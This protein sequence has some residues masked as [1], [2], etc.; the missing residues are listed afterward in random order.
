M[1]DRLANR[2]NPT[3]LYVLELLDRINGRRP[4]GM[5]D[6]KIERPKLKQYVGQL[7]SGKSTRE[8]ELAKAALI[9]WIDEMLVNAPW[10]HQKAWERNTLEFEY[11]NTLDRA[12]LFYDQAKTAKSLSPPDALETFYLCVALGFL[13]VYRSADILR[14][15][16]QRSSAPARPQAAPAPPPP[17]PTE[18]PPPRNF[19]DSWPMTNPGTD[20]SWDKLPQP[21]G[22]PPAPARDDMIDE[23]VFDRPSGGPQQGV[24]DLPNTL[25]GWAAPVYA[26]I[27]PGRQRPFQPKTPSDSQRD[28]R[29]LSGWA[30][31]QR[32]MIAFLWAIMLTVIAGGLA[33][34]THLSPGG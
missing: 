6:P 15:N 20:D 31:C 7:D 27:V 32:A 24:M 29:P 30:S 14:R 25:D 18:A 17:R 13:G 10:P 5:P 1:N 11:F 33:A 19:G 2:V 9:Y 8:D 4:G 16:Q 3:I 12:W 28:A 26:Q 22:A 23:S 34:F 21:P